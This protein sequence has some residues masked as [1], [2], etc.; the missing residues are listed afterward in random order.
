MRGARWFTAA[1]TVLLVAAPPA[2]GAAGAAETAPA[3]VSTTGP[4]RTLVPVEMQ[5]SP[6]LTLE[7]T[8]IR[9]TRWSTRVV[10]GDA[11]VL[12]GQVVT[13]DGAL[14]GVEVGLFQRR[15]GESSW[16]SRGTATADPDT[17]VFSFGC[18]EPTATTE[19]R[20]VFD[21]TLVHG[22]SQA[23]R[24]VG[25]A[26]RVPDA[27]SRIAAERFALT[28]SV[29]P[30]YVGRSVVLQR[31][32]CADCRWASVQTR[33]T[34]SRSRWRFTI[35]SS[36]FS[37]RRWFRVVVPADRRYVRSHGDHVWWVR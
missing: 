15:P 22:A 31:R 25:V 19:Y 28:G 20:A 8:S 24:K 11:A 1:L 18:L 6:G 34:T 21:G 3:C 10:H 27:M 17:G 29:S 33:E 26:R 37:G 5:R 35:D 12:E 32:S 36:T 30:R 13:D 2:T 14:G 23:V 4:A 9:W 16:T 7:E